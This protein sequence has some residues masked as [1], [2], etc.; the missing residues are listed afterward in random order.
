[1]FERA[2]ELKPGFIPGWND[3]ASLYMK[4]DRYDKALEAVQRALDLDPKLAQSWITRGN[5]LT[6]AQRHEESLDAYRQA[7]K[8]NP[9]SAGALSQV[10]HVLK[11]IGR[12]EESIEAFRKCIR[13]HP[14]F[15]EAYW[16]L[17]NLKT[18]EFSEDEVKVMQR[19][20]EDES[21]GDEP[22]VNFFLSLGKH[23]E[24]EKDYDR[25][26]EHYRRG[27]DLRR[28]HEIYDPVQTQVVHDRIIE[29]FNQEFLQDSGGLG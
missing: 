18:F 1:M 29:V 3:L 6:R 16:S 19:M 8:L 26:F 22:R 7:L 24:N 28:E 13:A 12:Q 23:Y 10:G 11:T 17:A 14:G 2:V 25:A 21:L 5:I 15:G 4:Q 27:N 20:V 9:L